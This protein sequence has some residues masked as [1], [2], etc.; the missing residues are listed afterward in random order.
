MTEEEK[1]VFRTAFEYDQKVLVRLASQ[2]AKYLD[3]WQSLNLF[4]AAGED[5]KYIADVHKTAFEDENI[6]ALYYIYSMANV[7]ASKD[8]AE[9]EACSQRQK[10]GLILQFGEELKELPEVISIFPTGSFFTCYPQVT[11]TDRD[12]LV[13]V[14]DLGVGE[15]AILS[16]GYKVS[17]SDREEYDLQAEGGFQTFR[18]G[19]INLIVTE[20]ELFYSKF[21]DATLLAKELNLLKKED[22]IK[23]F[24]YVLYGKI[25]E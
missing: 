25:G 18:K 22:R 3:Q 19:N 15:T 13:R 1:K 14:T 11:T 12:Y 20:D 17:V 23:L 10:N 21:V 5:P 2:R 9:C 8:R 16:K 24:A 4:F 7:Q 6:L